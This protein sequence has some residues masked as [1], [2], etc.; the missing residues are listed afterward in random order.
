MMAVKFDH[1][2]NKEWQYSYGRMSNPNDHFPGDPQEQKASDI[3]WDVVE[4]PDGGFR[5]VACAVDPAAGMNPRAFVLDIAEDESGDLVIVGNN[6]SNL[7]DSYVVRFTLDSTPTVPAPTVAHSHLVYPTGDGG[8]TTALTGSLEVEASGEVWADSLRT[9]TFAQGEGVLVSGVLDGEWSTFTEASAG[10]GWDGIAFADGSSGT[11]IDVTV[12]EVQPVL[13]QR[14]QAAVSTHGSAALTLKGVTISNNE[15]IGLRVASGYSLDPVVVTSNGSGVESRIEL[16]SGA[17]V[18]VVNGGSVLIENGALIQENGQAGILAR[19][20]AS[21]AYLHDAN[22]R[23]NGGVG[24]D[25]QDYAAVFFDRY[26]HDDPDA[27][28]TIS[29]NEGGGINAQTYSVVQAGVYTSGQCGD[30]CNN[31]IEDHY[32][33]GGGNAPFDAKASVASVLNAE[34]NFWGEDVFGNPI[35]LETQHGL[36][37]DGSSVIKVQPLRQTPPAAREAGAP[38][39]HVE[40]PAGG[41]LREDRSAVKQAVLE[42]YDLASQGDHPAAFGLLRAALAAAATEEDRSLAFATAT[43]FLG[44]RDDPAT[45]DVLTA[46]AGGQGSPRRPW[47]LQALAT[48]QLAR[49]LTSEA[50][51]A[52]ATLAADYAG[53]ST[54]STRSPPWSGSPSGTPTRPRPSRPSPSCRPAGPMGG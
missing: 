51:S 36:D 46:F 29:G 3:A 4:R 42:A 49:G 38:L 33:D 20:T 19:G 54:L 43:H 39:A 53:P 16:N 14:G 34:W 27:V 45:A 50:R 10:Q 37:E 2:G 5:I 7:D 32:Q 18:A 41:Q 15:V 30:W 12:E 13:S 9:F 26:T 22:V 6:S 24:V 35:L 28:T 8:Y 11:L 1:D 21:F 17:G 52:A 31:V 23:N 48:A 44:E 40:L 47:A 25:A